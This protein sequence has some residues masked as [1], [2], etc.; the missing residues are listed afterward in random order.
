LKIGFYS[1]L[2]FEVVRY[3]WKPKPAA[4]VDILVV[5][6][7]V[8]EGDVARGIR[9]TAEVADGRPAVFVPGNHEFWGFP[10]EEVIER[11]FEAA[12]LHGVTMLDGQGWVDV[13]GCLFVGGTLWTDRTLNVPLGQRILGRELGEP[14][15]VR[16]AGIDRRAR[17]ADGLRWHRRMVSALELALSQPPDDRPRI[18]AT[19]HAPS[20]RSLLPGRETDPSGAFAASDL[21][22]LLAA[23]ADLWIH[24]HVHHSVDLA[25]PGG[26]RLLCNPFG[27]HGSNAAFEEAKSVEVADRRPRPVGA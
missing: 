13:G 22:H 20:A 11:G 19:H 24:G 12:D 4:D 10:Y 14:V 26:T 5:A 21:E 18:V 8:F 25:C 3:D 2:H 1:D 17:P 6:G 9:W 15:D 7:D 27:Y 23:G 16:G